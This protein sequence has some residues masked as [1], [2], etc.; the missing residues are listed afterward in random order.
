MK[1]TYLDA[2]VLIAAFEGRAAFKKEKEGEK[3]KARWQRALRARQLAAKILNDPDRLFVVSDYIRLEVLPRPTSQEELEEVNFLNDIFEHA[4]EDLPTSPNLTR[5][6][7]DI[8]KKY[9]L[10]GMD[11]LHV[12]AAIIA[13]VDELVTM[14]GEKNRMC[15]VRE[16]KVN[17][18]DSLRL[19]SPPGKSE[20]SSCPTES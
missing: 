7:L 8:A 4:T 3:E 6:A 13:K 19:R 20:G 12:G 2:C 5:Q 11:A 9:N 18:L 14:E 15:R 16:I 17:S 10:K 1:R